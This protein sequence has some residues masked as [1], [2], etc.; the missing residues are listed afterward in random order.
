MILTTLPL[1]V[2][3]IKFRPEIFITEINEVSYRFEFSYNVIDHKFYVDI[4]EDLTDKVIIEGRKLMYSHNLLD[5][6]LVD[7]AVIPLDFSGIC[8]EITYENLVENI[9][10]YIIT[11]DT[12]AQ[13]LD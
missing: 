12:N 8:N 10:L 7:F 9:K 13:V 2:D 4:Y 6:T 3:N 11:G 1:S 5:M